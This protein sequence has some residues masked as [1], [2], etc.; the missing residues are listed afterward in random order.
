MNSFKRI[1]L[2]VAAVCTVV[3]S[4]TALWALSRMG[5]QIGELET[6]TFS[7]KTTAIDTD[8]DNIQIAEINAN[9]SLYPSEDGECK[10]VFTE[11]EHLT[12]DIQNDGGTL[13]IEQKDDSKWYERFGV[14]VSDTYYLKLYL[15]KAQY[16]ELTVAVISGDVN[17]PAG[18][19]FGDI[20][21]STV[22]GDITLDKCDGATI[23]IATVSGDVKAH[24]LT[25]KTFH[26]DT[27]SGTVN[28]PE[29]VSGAGD[30]RIDTT[31]G[32][33]LVTVG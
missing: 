17:L 13:K 29:S 24:L 16:S 7:E 6:V 28:V 2:T 12:F 25:D 15:P 26:I 3:G 8:F 22:S 5:W 21:I 27:D 30:C 10:V 18:F 11:T 9:I 32:D 33:I 14:I 1:I 19:S 31:S 20:N 23:D 4:V